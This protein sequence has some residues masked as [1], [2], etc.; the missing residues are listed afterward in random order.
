MSS[1]YFVPLIC[2]PAVIDGPG[3]YVTRCG[4]V[5]EIVKSSNRHDY[6][7]TGTYSNNVAERWHKSG[8]IF[9][10]KETANDVVSKCSV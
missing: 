7:C 6:G 4:E 2:L 3:K 8:R 5:V 9:A 10:T 1:A